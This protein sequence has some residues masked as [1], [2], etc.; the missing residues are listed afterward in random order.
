LI[1]AG[2]TARAA[3]SLWLGWEIEL[4]GPASRSAVAPDGADLLRRA[5]ADDRVLLHELEGGVLGGARRFWE[6]LGIGR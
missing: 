1:D 5:N 2:T 3:V 4:D 6:A